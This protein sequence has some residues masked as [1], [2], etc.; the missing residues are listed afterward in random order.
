MVA[1]PAGTFTMGSPTD[2]LWRVPD[3]TQHRVT[4]TK[5][6]YVSTCEVTQSEWQAVMGWNESSVRGTRK[7]VEQVT[8]YDA[9]SYCNQRSA[10]DG[11]T[12][13][14]TIMGANYD[15]NHIMS[16]TVTW[17]QA[18]EGYRLLTEAEWE[19]AC[20][21][22]STYAFCN[23]GITIRY[24]GPL[25]ANLGQVGWHC[26]NAWGTTHDVGG[27]RANDWGLK[28]MHGNVWEWCW[29]R[30]GPYAG[31]AA[32]PTGPESGSLRGKRG[33]GWFNYASDC[34]SAS[35]MSY[36]PDGRSD[37]LGLRLCMT[38]R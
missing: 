30:Y 4:L 1:I 29:D 35:R 28:D 2:E 13:A 14:Y 3:E 26:G 34:R 16:A 38:A 18:A 9:V 11:Y 24:C 25:D 36:Y 8:W 27:K 19:Y 20:R 5:P 23:G 31:N 12:P 10:V 15:G 22:T 21:A 33:G 17:D 6:M 32:N 37:N 7:P